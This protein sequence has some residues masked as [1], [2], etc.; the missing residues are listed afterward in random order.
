MAIRPGKPLYTRVADALRKEIR[1]GR[2]KPGDELPAERELRER[3][4]VSTT[5]VRAAM[6]QLRSEGIVTTR[7]G[8]RSKV[9]EEGGLR[10]LST[11]ISEGAGF[12]TM[13]ERTGR[14]PAT[15]TT[16]T[17]APA[18]EEVA[19]ALGIPV[20]EEVVVRSRILRT[21][22]EPPKG[23]AVS[24]FPTWVVEAAPNLTDPSVSGLPVWLR[25]A[26]GPT[27]ST[28]EVDARMPTAE[29]REQLEIPEDTPVLIIK[30][31]TLDQQHRVL[32]FIDKVTVAGRMGYGWKYGAIPAD[33]SA[34]GA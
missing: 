12:Y 23:S 25:E 30:G 6:V 26:F 16:V 11:D 7:Q 5:T 29:E 28:D 32:H 24:Y 9:R 31:L 4:G 15:A 20:G 19:Q 18:N 33:E 10:R 34:E 17:R 1:S 22:G 8:E 2:Y 3:F 21:E 13:L 27:Y 14:E